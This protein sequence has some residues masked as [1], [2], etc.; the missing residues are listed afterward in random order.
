M[1]EELYLNCNW[2]INY[3]KTFNKNKIFQLFNEI[4][5]DLLA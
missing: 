1:K 2:L 4:L 5:K 3:D